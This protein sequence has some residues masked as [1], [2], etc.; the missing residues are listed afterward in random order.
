MWRA[1]VCLA[2]IRTS[3]AKAGA[4]SPALDTSCE[5]RMKFSA[6]GHR[7]DN[8]TEFRPVKCRYCAAC[9]VARPTLVLAPCT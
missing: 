6:D 9:A 5:N 4:V 2:S 3:C 8:T 1:R 7:N